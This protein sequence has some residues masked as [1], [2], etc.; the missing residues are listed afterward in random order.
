ME[1]KFTG[2]STLINILS[3]NDV[4]NSNFDSMK[5]IASSEGKQAD[6]MYLHYVLCHEGP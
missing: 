2:L 5:L 3:V 6:L 4:L 1:Q